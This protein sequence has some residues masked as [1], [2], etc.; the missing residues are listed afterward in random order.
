MYKFP[1]GAARFLTAALFTFVT[2]PSSAAYLQFTYTNPD[3]FYTSHKVEGVP[4]VVDGFEPPIPL[5]SISFTL[6]EQDLSLQPTTSFF[7]RQ[8]NLTLGSNI[9]GILDFPIN[10]S[11]SS[12][13]QV[14]LDQTGQITSWNLVAFATEL[15]TPETH[16]ETHAL[17]D[18]WVNV[19]S[20]S[21]T[22]DLLTER[23]HAITWHH[24][25]W[26]QAAQ[27][28]FNYA[29]ETSFSNWTVERIPVPEPGLAGLL[30]SGLAV[31]FWCRRDD[32]KTAR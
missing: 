13:A 21:T 30:L 10:L 16:V 15:I 27:L 5:F 2:L 20:N 17:I 9:E 26:I 19:R 28:E 31:L 4:T 29:D 23:F 6:P 12:Y 22:G 24:Q 1:F 14:S 7:T 25:I 3:L 11:P 18:E 8:L 32:K